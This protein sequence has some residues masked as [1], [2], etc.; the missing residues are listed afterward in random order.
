MSVRRRLIWTKVTAH[1]RAIYLAAMRD[2]VEMR[3]PAVVENSVDFIFAQDREFR[4]LS[5]NSAAAAVIGR[6][7]H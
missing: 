6:Q 7:A 1:D 2:E 4:Y 3:K 5:I